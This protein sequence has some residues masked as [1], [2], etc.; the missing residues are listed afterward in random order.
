MSD[1]T[2]FDEQHGFSAWILEQH[3]SG[4]GG[5]RQHARQRAGTPQQWH[6]LE[7]R[8]IKPHLETVALIARVLEAPTSE[9]MAAA[10]YVLRV[11]RRRT[12]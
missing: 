9:A 8:T 7:T 11:R 6:S 1:S 3:E 2:H 12:A 4:T 5:R 10:G